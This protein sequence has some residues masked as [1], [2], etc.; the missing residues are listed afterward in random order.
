MKRK[1]IDK[2]QLLENWEES[3]FL[4]DL[5]IEEKAEI[6]T[7]LL[8]NA[9]VFSDKEIVKPYFDKLRRRMQVRDDDNGG[10]PLNAI[11]KGYHLACKHLFEETDNILKE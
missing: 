5:T 4:K 6:L 10:E 2:A 7:K 11:D 3:T 1:L 9:Y 8:D